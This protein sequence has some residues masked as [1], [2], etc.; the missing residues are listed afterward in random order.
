MKRLFITGLFRSGTTFLA[1][2]LNAHPQLSVASDPFFEF[3]KLVRN[4]WWTEQNP[5]FNASQPLSDY[6]QAD[7]V[8]V[9]HFWQQALGVELE[10]DDVFFLSERIAS[11]ALPYSPKV[12]EHVQALMDG[13]GSDVLD[14]LY[15]AVA[16]AYPT[17][18]LQCVGTKEVW[19]DEFA[20]PFL[21]HFGEDG[22]VIHILRDPRAI[23]ASNR[24]SSTGAYPV[25]FLI[26]QWR[27]SVALALKNAGRNGFLQLGYEDIVSQPREAFTAMCNHIGVAF[28]PNVTDGS[29][30]V[31]G[32][33]EPWQQNSSHGTSATIN[34]EYMERWRTVL[35]EDEIAIIEW[36]CGPEMDALGYERTQREQPTEA[37][38]RWSDDYP[39]I[40]D[41][42]KPYNYNLTPEALE[43]E[44][45]RLQVLNGHA[46]GA[47]NP[48]LSPEVLTAL[49]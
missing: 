48:L 39:N 26:R 4:V 17:D 34:K 43:Q 10:E 6:F 15:A 8:Y 45:Q 12:I 49:Q 27:K 47:A 21:D 1:R 44:L 11:A 32:A 46:A 35:P 28:H 36:L 30:Y 19:T 9:Q 40:A 7:A 20:G 25:L 2:A 31:D 29:K 24:K 23:I 14:Q 41:W 13:T 37:L 38:A 33:G 5:E 18:D 16:D 3:W 42:I 22:R